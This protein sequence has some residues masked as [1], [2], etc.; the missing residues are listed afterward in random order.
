MQHASLLGSNGH[1][2]TFT[3]GV[4]SGQINVFIV[5]R[6]YKT[7]QHVK[8][9]LPLQVTDHNWQGRRGNGTLVWAFISSPPT[10]PLFIHY[11]LAALIIPWHQITTAS[12]H[13]VNQLW[14][15]SIQH[16][17]FHTESRCESVCTVLCSVHM[18]PKQAWCDLELVNAA[19]GTFDYRRDAGLLSS[20]TQRLGSLS[21]GICVPLCGGRLVGVTTVS[22]IH[23]WLTV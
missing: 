3:S 17:I 12:V 14:Y 22:F 18:Q 13:H 2:F 21:L 4:I 23:C 5:S 15:K 16:M 1:H 7:P 20:T 6:K 10:S 19:L 11:L 9:Q 8:E